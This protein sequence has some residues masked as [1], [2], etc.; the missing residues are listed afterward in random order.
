MGM[1]MH[2]EVRGYVDSRGVRGSF[3]RTGCQQNRQKF[4]D[5]QRCSSVINQGGS[6]ED[7]GDDDSSWENGV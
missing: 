7:A 1:L 3:K 5:G 2:V 6:V 4:D